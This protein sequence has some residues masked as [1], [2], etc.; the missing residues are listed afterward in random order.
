[1]FNHS[2][3]VLDLTKKHREVNDTSNAVCFLLNHN[4]TEEIRVHQHGNA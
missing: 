4:Y 2:F 1:M 3:S